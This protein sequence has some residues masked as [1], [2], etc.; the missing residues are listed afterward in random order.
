MTTHFLR[1][2]PLAPLQAL[3]VNGQPVWH[4]ALQ[5][6]ETLRLRNLPQLA[7][8]LAIPQVNDQGDRLDWYAPVNGQPIAW[9]ATSAEE[10][11]TV[12]S[13]LDAFHK[14]IT[15]LAGKAA[16]SEKA[17]LRLFAAL[18]QKIAHFPDANHVY[19]VNGQAVITFW[20][21]LKHNEKPRQDPFSSLRPERPV[22]V[23]SATPTAV[24]AL[25][26][27]DEPEPPAPTQAVSP[28]M[29]RR[30]RLW[31]LPVGVAAAAALGAVVWL[32]TPATQVAP[33]EVVSPS[34]PPITHWS[35]PEMAFALPLDKATV[36][37]APPS[38]VAAASVASV[39]EEEKPIPDNALLLPAN[40]VRAGSVTFLNGNWRVAVGIK[41]PRVGRQPIIRYQLNKGAGTARITH[42]DG[43]TC[44]SQVQTGLMQ[45]GNLVINSKY[46][47]RCSDNSRYK[48]PEISCKAA[49]NEVA[50]CTG[51]FGNNTVLPLTITRENK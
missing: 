10:R 25:S 37:P 27:L 18:L 42:A 34:L 15:V 5:I 23:A 41:T 13:Q 30:S 7:D 46:T 32:Q 16:Q 28:S 21:F 6:R 12:L 44:R 1:S 51:D 9:A 35:L 48:M 20:G 2:G 3:G 11:Q 39:A 26:L 8:I 31:L 47:A 36:A 22:S 24:P 29:P 49:A 17:S 14:A 43:V 4:T 19:L 38:P 50:E 40:S 45:S 33:A